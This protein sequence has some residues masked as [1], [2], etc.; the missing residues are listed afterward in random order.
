MARLLYDKATLDP[1]TFEYLGDPDFSDTM[2]Y[3]V[4]CTDDS[5]FNGTTE[6]RITQTIEAGQASNGTVPRLD[7][8]VYTGLYCAHWPS[9]PA[10]VAQTDPLVAE[11]VPTFVLNATLDPATPFWEGKS[12]FEN[13]A[14]GYHLYVEGGPHAI[15]G[16]GYDCPDQIVA[17]FMVT[18]ARPAQREVVCEDWGDAVTWAYQPHIPENASDFGNA[19]NMMQA[20]HS[21]ISLQPEYF[22]SYFEEEKTVACPYGGTFT[23]GP[24]DVGQGLAFKNCAYIQGFALTGTGSYNYDTSQFSIEAQVSGD[25]SGALMYVYD[26][27]NGNSSVTGEYGGETVDLRR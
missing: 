21:E 17:D 7:G 25:K 3:N 23:F 6:E 26:N 22:Y 15:F 11:G 27:N 4:H 12:V 5:Y 18:G 20:T 1:E 16:W 2:F 14:D 9:A 10:D 24:S 8:S 13:L 19:L